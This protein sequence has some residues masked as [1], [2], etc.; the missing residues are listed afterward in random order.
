MKQCSK[1]NGREAG[2]RPSKKQ[3]FRSVS[4][5]VFTA[6][7]ILL[8]VL[9][10]VFIFW[11]CTNRLL[12]VSEDSLYYV[13]STGASVVAGLYG[14]TLT[15]YI[16]FLNQL[17]RNGDEDETLYDPIRLLKQNYNRAA[18]LLSIL[19]LISLLTNG[20]LLLYGTENTLLSD[21]AYRFLLDETLWCTIAALLAIVCFILMVVDPDKIQRI[22]RRYKTRID[23]ADN[24]PGSLDQFLRDCEE[25]EDIILELTLQAGASLS[26]K[27]LADRWKQKAVV[28]TDLLKG[29]ELMNDSIWEDVSLIRE[30]RNYALHASDHSVSRQMCDFAASVKEELRQTLEDVRAENTGSASPSEEF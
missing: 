4:D 1:G 10:H 11:D 9:P 16:F 12:T 21:T 17:Q 23:G 13:S 5:R 29:L 20:F 30:Y 27:H 14:I 26:P 25:M 28:S 24:V 22:S 7:V 8:I 2:G 19:T 6:V 3:V 18:I 15:G